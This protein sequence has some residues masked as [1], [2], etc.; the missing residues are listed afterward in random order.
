MSASPSPE[1]QLAFLNKLQR[2]FAEGDFSSTYKYALLIALAE[3]AVEVGQD[4]A[5][6]LQLSNKTLATKFID[7]YW[8]QAAPYS[9]AQAVPG[10]LIQ[11][12][13]AQAAVINLIAKFRAT[14][15]GVTPLSA[16]A[17]PEFEPLRQQ[18]SLTVSAQPITYLQNLG[19]ETQQI[20]YERVRG[21]LILKSGVAYCLRR[22]QPLV[23]Q[24]ARRHWIDLLKRNRL[25]VPMLGQGDDLESFLFE[26]SRQSLAIIGAGLRRID[27]HCFYC[28]AKVNESDVDHFIPFSLYPR[29]LRMF[30]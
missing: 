7:L 25:N 3:L 13:G 1:A 12:N 2:E 28:R 9:V 17:M 24:L 19:G 16:K 10:V 15:P 29:D 18:V 30:G 23:Q 8:Q 20:L 6:P 26:T 5:E 27:N 14:Y 21:G 4:D 22:F 11:N